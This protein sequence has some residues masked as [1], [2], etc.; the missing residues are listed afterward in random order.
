[1]QKD[2]TVL[3]TGAS[4]GIG[5]ELAREFARNGH[6]LVLVAPSETELNTIAEDFIRDHNIDVTV[7]AADLRE[8]EAPDEVFDQL[9]ASGIE[10][11]IL[12]N[13][14]GFG[15]RGKFH[16][17]TLEKDIGMIRLN[18]EAVVRLTKLFLPPMLERGH[19]RILN[20]ASIA[21]F[22]PGPML[23]VYHASKAFV[24]SLTEALA[25]ELEDTGVTATALCP[26]P[27]DTDFFPKA[28]MVETNAFQK[29][30][31]MAPQ[32]VATLAYPALMR[33][34]R[35]FVPGAMNKA[36]VFARRISPIGA[37][38]KMNE[39]MYQETDPEDQKRVPGEIAQKAEA[40]SDERR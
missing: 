12:V 40:E 16:E 38:A 5:Y 27:T 20:V 25:T 2:K 3:V 15:A 6:D 4:S 32:E 10:V 37:Q 18:I 8:S 24:L 21:G 36:M 7:V 9:E 31:V 22:E 28:G 1:M 19:G 35:V 29:A 14:A 11:D 13:N 30:N 23:A 17:I 33:A 34:E 26:G 39:K